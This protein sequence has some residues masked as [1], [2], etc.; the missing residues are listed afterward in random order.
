MRRSM[1]SFATGLREAWVLSKPYFTSEEKWSAIGLLAAI[2]AL[3]LF[4]VFISVVYNYWQN[5]FFN[6]IQA[7]DKT[8]VIDLLFLYYIMPGSHLPMAGFCVIA[9]AAIIV[10]VYA[11]YLN[12]MLQIRWRQWLTRHYI[13]D[14]FADRAFYN[15]SL[16]PGVNAI[17]D[18]PDQRISEDLRDFTATTLSLGIDFISNIVTLL[19]FIFVLYSVSGSIRLFGVIINGYMVWVALLYAIFGTVLTQL[20]GRKL[21]GLNFF[22]QKLEADFRYGL[23]RVRENTEA[24]AL[25]RGEPN[26]A[27]ALDARFL[28]VKDNFWAI[29]RRT[30]ALNFFTI[31]FSQVAGI[32]PTVVILPRYFAKQIGFGALNQIPNAFAQVQGSFSWFVSSY[33]TLV[34]WRATV[35]RLTGF[36]EAVAAARTARL[37]GPGHESGGGALVFHNLTLTL[38]D[39]RK[40]LNNANLTLPPGETVV[41]TGPSG[42]GKTTL[43]RAIAGIWPFGEG[44]VTTPSGKALFLPQRPYFPLGTL[45][46][47]VVYPALEDDVDDDVVRAALLVVELPALPARLHD[48]ENWGL[49]LSGGE[50]QRLSVARALVAKP[51]WLFLDEALSNLDAPLAARIEA[52]LERELPETTVV[53]ITHRDVK[54][55]ASRH[56][57]LD[58]GV[59][60]NAAG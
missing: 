46:R 31:G 2:I 59:L 51:D 30:K 23:V 39:G 16:K 18:N 22:Q 33:Q 14:W 50:Q 52:V 29:M 11:F 37:G 44:K 9:A 49:I 15:L 60:A 42:A 48:T 28:N 41:L 12:Q 20:I 35:S 36:Q 25:Y 24:I 40:L 21:I 10:S 58:P 6:S 57:T 5:D 13:T 47:S 1:S 7:Y 38:P 17:V 45:K 53:A 43:F 4:L 19:S 34:G 54:T 8:A 26:E 55:T 56:L 3:N 27:A 32:F